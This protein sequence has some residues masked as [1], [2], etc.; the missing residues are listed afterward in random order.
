MA[1][2]ILLERLICF[3]CFSKYRPQPIPAFHITCT[4]WNI[5]FI[6]II[7]HFCCCPRLFLHNTCRTS[8]M[9]V[10]LAA[11]IE[12]GRVS[13]SDPY[14]D[15][16][17]CVVLIRLGWYY[18]FTRFTWR[19]NNCVWG[20]HMSFPCT[21]LLLF[22]YAKVNTVFHSMAHLMCRDRSL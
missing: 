17:V 3:P 7:C 1:C 22:N 9:Q 5:T 13:M 6:S 10:R 16:T 20:S 15:V 21:E 14:C 2:V 19:G 8:A 4:A 18:A 11:G 12:H